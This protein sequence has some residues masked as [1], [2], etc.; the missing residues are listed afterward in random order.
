MTG[1][2]RNVTERLQAC[3][4]CSGFNEEQALRLSVEHLSP[5][6]FIIFLYPDLQREHLISRSNRKVIFS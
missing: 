6:H 3:S 5:Q 2:V 4:M 1:S